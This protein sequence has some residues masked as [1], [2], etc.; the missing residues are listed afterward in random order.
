MHDAGKQHNLR[1]RE[2]EKNRSKKLGNT[3]IVVLQF[4]A[5]RTQLFQQAAVITF[6]GVKTSFHSL[7]NSF[8]SN[9]SY[10]V[11]NFFTCT[12]CMGGSY[13]I[14]FLIEFNSLLFTRA[15]GCSHS[16]WS[17]SFY[18]GSAEC[19][20]LFWLSAEV[21]ASRCLNPLI[22]FTHRLILPSLKQK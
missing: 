5:G 20:N 22:V 21:V 3:H 2:R 10:C 11:H 17:N 12:I 1:E 13:F 8:D 7:A 16:L 6:S 19:Q 18:P 14:W 9:N 4:T 15:A